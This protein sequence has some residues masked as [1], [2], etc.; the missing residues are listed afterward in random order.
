[1]RWK[2]QVRFGERAGETIPVHDV[3]VEAVVLTV[4]LSRRHGVDR[5]P[6]QTRERR[7]VEPATVTLSDVGVRRR[8]AD[9]TTSGSPT[10]ALP[11]ERP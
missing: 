2:L 3:W 11:R 6:G 7:E 10:S 9:G 4:S 1:M 8:D 5:P